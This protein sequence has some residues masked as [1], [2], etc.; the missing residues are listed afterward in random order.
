MV[1]VF[2]KEKSAIKIKVLII[3][4]L[5]FTSTLYSAQFNSDTYSV[6]NDLFGNES[7]Y[8]EVKIY[9]QFNRETYWIDKIGDPVFISNAMVYSLEKVDLIDFMKGF[10]LQNYNS[11][12]SKGN[13]IEK[14]K[15]NKNIKLKKE[16]KEPI[17]EIS[18]PII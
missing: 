1:T 10:D 9:Y 15:L 2:L 12:V 4:G 16:F 18:Y 14:K 11:I 7:K 5:L 8:N 3:F 13:Q 17:S 6:I